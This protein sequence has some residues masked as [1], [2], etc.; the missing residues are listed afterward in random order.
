[1]DINEKKKMDRLTAPRSRSFD[2][3]IKSIRF[4]SFPKPQLQNSKAPNETDLFV[5]LS[6]NTLNQFRVSDLR[7]P[8]KIYHDNAST[9][10]A[11]ENPDV[12]F[13]PGSLEIRTPKLR[14]KLED[15]VFKSFSPLGDFVIL[16]FN[17]I[18]LRSLE[19]DKKAFISMMKH[20]EN[21]VLME[22]VDDSRSKVEE[23]AKTNIVF[24]R[25]LHQQF[26][27][28]KKEKKKRF[29][30]E[31]LV[32]VVYLKFGIKRS[33]R[34]FCFSFIDFIT[35]NLLTLN[36]LD[37]QAPRFLSENKLRGIRL[38]T[39][40]YF[41][42]WVDESLKEIEIFC[43]NENSY[44]VSHGTLNSELIFQEISSEELKKTEE[45]VMKPEA[46]FQ[47]YKLIVS[48][49]RT[50]LFLLNTSKNHMSLEEIRE[51]HMENHTITTVHIWNKTFYVLTQGSIF[52]FSLQSNPAR[53]MSQ[54]L[55]KSQFRKNSVMHSMSKRGDYICFSYKEADKDRFFIQD[56]NQENDLLPDENITMMRIEND[57]TAYYRNSKNQ[58]FANFS[59]FR[60]CKIEKANYITKQKL[61]K[62]K[63]VVF[64]NYKGVQLTAS[65][66][67]NP[68]FDL[69]S[70]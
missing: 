30:S 8:I 38:Q 41:D 43:V 31:K 70:S 48:K 16:N 59:S 47:N 18:V 52:I 40:R 1:M 29:F 61:S 3:P 25:N 67:R 11:S 66:I 56:V 35:G 46:S 51:R 50:K 36:L 39:L 19:S 37:Y 22:L 65:R 27:F 54:I 58:I 34:T 10:F 45:E 17:H 13:D 9:K 12:L 60:Q 44:L 57:R 26:I 21:R 33:P 64:S 5:S 68:S 6:D 28:G 42:A 4:S 49:T 24:T 2:Q 69:K 7:T 63:S 53:V 20:N 32:Y 62:I 55:I 14:I 15:K 23:E